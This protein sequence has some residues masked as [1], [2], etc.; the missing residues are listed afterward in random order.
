MLS[1]PATSTLP[2]LW[3]RAAL[4]Q[5]LLRAEPAV[6]KP[7]LPKRVSTLHGPKSELPP[8][9]PPPEVPPPEVPPFEVPPLALE[10]PFEPPPIV[11][12]LP[13]AAVPPATPP[14]PP[15][16]RPLRE[17]SLLPQPESR[18]T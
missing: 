5:S 4:I 18:A 12:P 14:S 2:S 11:P 15:P 8:E 3:R 17:S 7:S 6:T 9:V 1:V 16:D 13:P 10:P